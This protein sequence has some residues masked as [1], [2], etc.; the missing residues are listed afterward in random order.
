MATKISV[1]GCACGSG[2]V[3]AACC[4]RFIEGNETAPSAE[5][6]MRSR[7]TAYTREDRDYLL[8]TWASETRPDKLEFDEENFKSP[9]WLGL[10][11]HRAE[12]QGD[13]AVVEFTARYRIGGGSARRMHEASRFRR[14]CACWVYVNS[15]VR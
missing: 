9:T 14:E 13:N 10:K 3:L 4:G 1:V 5:A 2:K 15:E 6:L 7:Y 8:K 11:I 12:E